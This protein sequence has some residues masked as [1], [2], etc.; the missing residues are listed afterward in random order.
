MQ[1]KDIEAAVSS[2][3][4]G[5]AKRRRLAQALLDRPAVLT[6]GRSPAP[7]GVADLLIALRDAG[8]AD[9]SAPVCADC[10]KPLRTFQRRDQDWYCSVCGPRRK[11]CASC[12][13]ERIIA[14]RDRRGR[15]RCGRC[16]D[17]DDRDPLAIL[18]E[19]VTKLDPSLPADAIAAAAAGIFSRPAH[20]QKLAWTIE[21]MPQLLT[22]DG[23]KAPMPGVLRL[24]DA[25]CDAGAQ[26]TIRPACPRCRRVVRLHRRI[27]DHWLCR[28][29][30]AK[31]RAQPCARCGVMRE[32]AS[33]DEQGRP[34]CAHCFTSDPAN[35]E[36]CAAC[37][38]RRP[39]SVR[40]PNGP[41]CQ[42]CRVLPT[43]PCSICERSAPCEISMATGQ[44]WCKAC[45]QRWA[46]CAG[47]GQMRPVRGGSLA[48]P[49]CATCTR[50]DP[51]F[52]RSCPTC[53][54]QTRMR[55]RRPCVRCAVRQR[56]REL[57]GDHHG[58]IRPE[59]QA[60]YDNLA[61]DTRPTTVQRWLDTS[62]ATGILHELGTGARPLTHAALDE[63]PDGKPVEHLRSVLVAT[64]ALP[65]RDE[66]L[67]R[68]ERWITRVVGERDDADEQQM[69]HRYAV[70]HVLRRLRGRL[71]GTHA[72]HG[73]AVAAQ[74]RVRAALTFLDWLTAHGL[75]LATAR[76]GDLE[77][78]LAGEDTTHRHEVGH[79]LRWANRQKLTRLDLPAVR[80]DGPSRVLDTEARWEQARWLLHDDTVQPE[81]RVAG[82][83]VLLY[84][85][86]AAAISR[87]TL[88]QIETSDHQVRIRLGREPVILPD[89]LDTLVRHLVATRSG[90]AALGD[91]GTSRWLFPGGRPGR[92]ISAFRLAERLRQLGI[93]SRPSRSTALFQLATDLPAA[94]LARMLGIHISV[95]A[96]WQRASSGDWTNYAAEVSR[97][98]E[99]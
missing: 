44:P 30:V 52:W 50:P 15:P 36:P 46:S 7:R 18:T 70:W 69:L 83:L 76:Q 24:I 28:N 6:D 80:W 22:G 3:A 14:S 45:Q 43:M 26:N 93:P 97:R 60:L 12:G 53:G 57:L 34:L 62:A 84:A 11:R 92:P 86:T 99:Q 35:Q 77:A 85:Q 37:R 78:W 5:R 21:D 96:A 87:L 1:R 38:R 31:S 61:N 89:P 81:D 8:A 65:P 17:R 88:D 51:S 71:D 63:L 2:V 20:L 32:A 90:H 16:P 25:L 4:G 29:C 33:R 13:G 54:D 68:L 40:T 9:V 49:L 56:L 59:L 10:G 94:V 48:Q 23:A 73:Q 55:A 66:H 91:Q 41:L 39:V 19:V 74:V 47:C 75:T 58:T 42:N 67:A 79:F 27:D 98:T 72:T 82:L 95:A 64:A